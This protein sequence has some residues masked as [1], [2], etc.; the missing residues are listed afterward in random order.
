MLQLAKWLPCKLM[1]IRQKSLSWDHKNLWVSE[2]WISEV[3][4]AGLEVIA[5]MYCC[6][7]LISY[8]IVMDM[9]SSCI[10]FLQIPIQWR[11]SAVYVW[12][13]P[14]LKVVFQLPLRACFLLA[15]QLKFSTMQRYVEIK[16]GLLFFINFSNSFPYTSVFELFI[17]Y[18]FIHIYV[19]TAYYV[20]FFR[21][22]TVC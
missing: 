16:L 21:W 11:N 22:F 18:L 20:I 13:M 9:H 6:L 19:I 10:F 2:T 4:P 15:P 1:L 5:A 8:H 7:A 3:Q 17:R 12:N 14:E